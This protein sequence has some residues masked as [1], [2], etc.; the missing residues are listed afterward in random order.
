MSNV[1]QW[2]GEL[3]TAIG[4]FNGTNVLGYEWR[5]NN[6]AALVLNSSGFLG[7]GTAS[8]GYRLDVSGEVRVNNTAGIRFPADPFGGGGDLGR[9]FVQQDAAGTERTSLVIRNDN[10]GPGGVEDNIRLQAANIF[11]EPNSAGGNLLVTT[12][13]VGI[14]T[15]TPAAKLDV[16]GTMRWQC[17]SSWWT[18]AGGRLCMEST[19]RAAAPMYGTSAALVTCR[20]LQARVCT[21]ADYQQTCGAGVN[22][23]GTAPMWYGDHGESDDWYHTNNSPSCDTGNGNDGAVAASGSSYPYRCC[24]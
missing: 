5:L 16:A 23:F 12:G 14:G 11:I 24:M 15:S 17:P 20:G 4:A 8:P 19:L 1:G 7:V 22:P 2:D 6:T 10:D 13:N 3:T 18:V 9:I 21:H